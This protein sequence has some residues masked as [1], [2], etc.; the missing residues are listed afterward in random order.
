MK[1]EIKELSI[2]EKM[3][4][5]VESVISQQS[6]TGFQK[7]YLMAEAIQEL[8]NMLTP[9]Y[10]KPIMALQGRKLGFKS[11][12]P[13]SEKEVKECLIEAVFLGLQPYG[14]EF[15]IIAGNCYPTKEG[16]G[17]LLK[18]IKGLR[19][20]IVPRLP[21][22]QDKSSAVVMVITWT[23]NGV[24]DTKE[25]DIPIKVNNFMGTDAIIGKA[26]RKARAWLYN[27]VTGS[28]VVDGD[29]T[30]IDFIVTSS[31][32]NKKEYKYSSDDDIETDLKLVTNNEQKLKLWSELSEAQQI[33]FKEKFDL[34]KFQ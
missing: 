25:L 34:I 17:A 9:D 4:G 27:T 28:E 33:E 5:I 19:Y 6:I 3:N 16:M 32:V 18:K 14:N 31:K 13:Y 29:V 26:T 7:A 22:I 8:S 30:D 24:T 1:E 10:M 2:P 20:D 23:Y 21:R 12:K 11:D 15:N